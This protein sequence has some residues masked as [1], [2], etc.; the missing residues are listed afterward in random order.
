MIK[1][2]YLDY[3]ATTPHDPEM[4][5][6]M[7]PYLE[8]HFGNPSSSHWY[9]E[10]TKRAVETAREQVASLLNCL[11]SEIVFTS[12]GTESNNWAIKGIAFAHRQRGNHIITS[13]I[14]HPAVTEVC[15]YLEG[16]GYAVTYL[17]VDEFGMVSVD[18]VE[19]AIT[20][21][22]ILITEIDR[23]VHVISGA[24]LKMKEIS[25]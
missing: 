24:C 21:Q 20:P 18:D 14:E 25:G 9:G 8:E 22:T 13:R 6:A 12:G 2:I 15:E 10:Q 4:I 11:P 19:R 3:N 23:A 17:P 5:A 1:P 16:T 7:R